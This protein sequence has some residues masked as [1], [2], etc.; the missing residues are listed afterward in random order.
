LTVLRSL[1]SFL[2]I[3]LSSLEGAATAQDDDAWNK[4]LNAWFMGGGFSSPEAF[5][6]YDRLFTPEHQ[7]ELQCMHRHW[8][9]RVDPADEKGDQ[10]VNSSPLL[11]EETGEPWT[12]NDL[13]LLDLNGLSGSEEHNC[14]L[15]S[16]R[17]E[18]VAVCFRIM[19][20]S[21]Y[22]EQADSI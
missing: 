14:S 5:Q 2:R 19:F 9:G 11:Q 18:F 8:Q 22:S 15:R 4:P 13:S 3:C 17:P 6:C 20:I 12:L 7:S 16:S 1:S 21:R 10:F